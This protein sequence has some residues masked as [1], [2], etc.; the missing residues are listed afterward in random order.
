MIAALSDAG[1]VRDRI[2]NEV[3]KM[4]QCNKVKRD[5]LEELFGKL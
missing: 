3:M 4:I 2:F 1:F 5:I